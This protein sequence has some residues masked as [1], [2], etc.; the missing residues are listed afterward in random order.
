MSRLMV[1]VLSALL[2]SG[3]ASPRSAHAQASAPV[4]TSVAW[5][6]QRFEQEMSRMDGRGR[7]PSLITAML[8]H[9]DS[10]GAA[11]LDSLEDGL[12]RLAIR[13]EN[14]H[15]AVMSVSHLASAGDRHGQLRPGI[16][17]RLERIHR[18]A[19]LRAPRAS[20][21]RRLPSQADTDAALRALEC[22]AQL[23]TREE[24]YV[25]AARSAVALL[26]DFG[27]A[28]EESLRRMLAAGRVLDPEARAEARRVLP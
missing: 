18:T 13:S 27:P 6:L 12:E 25:G 4:P 10:F 3:C 5:L 21:L 22:T 11:Q 2:T 24:P 15:V 23:A 17:A 8:A 16:V 26:R 20:A 7:V 14:E 19:V 1:L 9:P 28:G